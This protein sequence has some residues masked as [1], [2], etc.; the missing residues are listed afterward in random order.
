MGDGTYVPVLGYILKPS[1]CIK[2]WGISAIKNERGIGAQ[3]KWKFLR[4]TEGKWS[5]IRLE[6]KYWYWK[7]ILGMSETWSIA[8][9]IIIAMNGENFESENVDNIHSDLVT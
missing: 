1:T 7:Y 2:I 3:R 8:Q 6:N 5:I 9:K 4:F